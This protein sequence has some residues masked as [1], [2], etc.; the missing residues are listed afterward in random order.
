[1]ATPEKRTRIDEFLDRHCP[2]PD[3]LRGVLTSGGRLR[4]LQEGERL[5]GEDEVADCLWIVERGEVGIKRGQRIVRRQPG[6]VVGEAAFYREETGQPSTARRSADMVA[7]EPRTEVWRIDRAVVQGLSLEQRACWH[8]TM[9]RVLVAKLDE[10]TTQRAE[11]IADGVT[12]DDLLRR[13]VS[14]EGHEAAYAV[15]RSGSTGRIEPERTRAVL[16][17]SDLV[18]FS[19]FAR[20]LDPG[21]V[22]LTVRAYMDLQAEEIA[23]AS[24]HVDKFMG[25]GLMAYWLTPDEER[26]RDFA[27]RAVRA[28]LAVAERVAELAGGQNHP[29]DVRIGLH[30]GEAVIGDFGGADRI[31]F[32]LVGETVNTAS[33]Y[34]QARSCIDGHSLG[35][36]RLS[37]AVLGS[38]HDPALAGRFE[39]QPRRFAA[40][41]GRHLDVHASID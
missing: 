26:L 9:A 21:A 6:D 5:C 39:P 15:L 22:A 17:F 16:W 10:A 2:A 33:R 40:K 25:D 14:S 41:G 27:P 3:L 13:F 34:E 37:P 7:S 28:A 24:G 20:H 30:A 1:M 18:G 23:K 29:L 11:L 19:D 32:T 31:A 36:V 4:R 8:E 35:R 12:V 38:L